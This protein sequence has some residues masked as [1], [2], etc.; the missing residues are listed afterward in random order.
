MLDKKK[1]IVETL[2][3]FILVAYVCEEILTFIKFLKY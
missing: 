3:N 1:K 2:G